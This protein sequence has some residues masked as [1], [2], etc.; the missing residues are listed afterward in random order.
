[1]SNA[2]S[3]HDTILAAHNIEAFNWARKGYCLTRFDGPV[4]MT[5]AEREAFAR[6]NVAPEPRR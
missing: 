4:P 6:T 3:D 5:A 2:N 1:M